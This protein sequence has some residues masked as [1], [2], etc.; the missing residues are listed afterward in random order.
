MP[1]QVAVR[2]ESAKA[3]KPTSLLSHFGN[4]RTL[5]SRL[6]TNGSTPP[7]QVGDRVAAM[8]EIAGSPMRSDVVKRHEYSHI[9]VVNMWCMS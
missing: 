4:S 3:D 8:V 2:E 1:P 9:A 5:V 7:L 6:P